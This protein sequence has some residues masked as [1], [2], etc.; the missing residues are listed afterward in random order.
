M[1]DYEAY[2]GISFRHRR[3]QEYTRLN[4]EPPN[5]PADGTG[6]NASATTGSRYGSSGASC[7]V[8][9][10]TIRPSGTSASTTALTARIYRQDAQT[11]ELAEW[12]VDA[13]TVTLEREFDRAETGDLDR[14][15]VQR[16]SGLA[17]RLPG[18]CSPGAVFIS[19]AAYRDPDLVATISDCL[20][21][22]SKPEAA[23]RHL[24]AARARGTTSRLAVPAAVQ[25]LDVDWRESRGG[26]WARAAIMKDGRARSGSCRSTRTTGSPTGGIP[27]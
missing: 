10:S 14:D 12:P 25:V 27:P 9:R 22:A 26:R 23:V 7:P 2:A 24:L 3:V 11:A 4:Q 13:D 1:A 20:A 17:R 15:A 21:K 18:E 8:P 5:P 6:P 16:L 19:I